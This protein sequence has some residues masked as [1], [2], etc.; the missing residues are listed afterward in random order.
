[1]PLMSPLSAASK[2]ASATARGSFGFWYASTM[3]TVATS[4]TTVAAAPMMSHRL[5]PSSERF[6]AG[7]YS[8]DV[9]T[10][11]NNISV[12]PAASVGPTATDDSPGTANGS[13]TVASVSTTPSI[14]GGAWCGTV[15]RS[16][17][18]V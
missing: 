12:R 15:G 5:R 3:K 4:T 7:G 14:T 6:G 11:G 8:T 9:M 18:G 1:M 10:A 2:Y 17:V 13:R 16:P